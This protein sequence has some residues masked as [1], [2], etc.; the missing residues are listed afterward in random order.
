MRTRACL[1]AYT[2]LAAAPCVAGAQEE[3]VAPTAQVFPRVFPQPTGRNGMEEIL[4]AGDLLAESASFAALLAEPAPTL[5]MRRMA[6]ADPPVARA[7]ELLRIG[8]AKPIETPML[9]AETMA[10][11]WGRLRNLGRLVAHEM[12]VRFADGQTDRAHG[13][14]RDGLNLAIAAQRGPL[15]AGLVG[16]AINALVVGAYSRHLDQLSARD[17]EKVVSIVTAWLDTPDPLADVLRHERAY[18]I[19]QGSKTLPDTPVHRD[20]IAVLVRRLDAMA[21]Q[22]RLPP[23]QRKAPAPLQGEGPAVEVAR[24][25]DIAEALVRTTETFQREMGRVQVLGLHA[26]VRRFRWEFGRLPASLDELKPGRL[27]VDPFTGGPMRYRVTGKDTYEIA[28]SD[29]RP[30]QPQPSS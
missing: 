28:F 4:Q 15:I 30:T 21:D 13:C 10:L 17:C 7:I 3:S 24:R 22:I 8:L 16:T 2:L 20:A 27:G 26:A 1:L 11:P 12:Y 19:N 29:P 9:D 25:L 18:L 5:T 14:L 23:W 6:L